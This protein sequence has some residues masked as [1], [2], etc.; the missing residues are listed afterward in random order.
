MEPFFEIGRA[1][2][3]TLSDAG[4]QAQ[5]YGELV[6]VALP[7]I[8]LDRAGDLVLIN[9]SCPSFLSAEC[10]TDRPKMTRDVR[11]N[12]IDQRLDEVKR[13][14]ENSRKGF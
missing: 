7:N 13:D 5:L 3:I 10:G 14:I 11:Q 4:R 12:D 8:V 1:Y 9:T 6:E 2:R